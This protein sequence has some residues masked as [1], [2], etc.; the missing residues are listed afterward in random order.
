VQFANQLQYQFHYYEEQLEGKNCNNNTLRLKIWNHADQKWE[1]VENAVFNSAES[2]VRFESE[3]VPSLVILTA[4]EA[5]VI[6]DND[7]LVVKDFVLNQNY[8]NPF[9]PFTTIEFTLG[10]EMNIVLSV[11]N[12][13]GQ[14]VLE[15][16]N[17]KYSAG[18]H[19]ILFDGRSL[20]SGIYFYE[21]QTELGTTVMKMT[22][23]K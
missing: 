16:G 22:I 13:L 8:P 5:T 21:L 23:L 3:T 11:Y 9:N 7:P 10:R 2:M 17:G 20:T 1:E 4:D 14:K 12:V 6:V 19:D 15:L 18:S